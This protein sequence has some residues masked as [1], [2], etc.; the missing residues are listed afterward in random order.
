VIIFGQ[1]GKPVGAA[2]G[3]ELFL[4]IVKKKKKTTIRRCE[5][6]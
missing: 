4:I 2:A 5:T 3:M 1:K 6:G